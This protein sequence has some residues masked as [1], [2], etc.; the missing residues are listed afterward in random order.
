[1]AEDEAVE[2]FHMTSMLEGSGAA[3][4]KPDSSRRKLITLHGTCWAA[5]KSE[6][7]SAVEKMA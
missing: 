4:G 7:F 5:A 3:V 6:A 2:A 1:M